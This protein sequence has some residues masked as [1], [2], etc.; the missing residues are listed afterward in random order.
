[1]AA[2]T[3][4]GV[5]LLENRCFEDSDEAR[6]EI[7]DLYRDLRVTDVCDG[8]DLVGLRDHAASYDLTKVS[9][10][11]GLDFELTREVTLTVEYEIEYDFLGC[12]T[13]E[14]GGATAEQ[15]G[16]LDEGSLVLGQLRPILSWDRR[17]NIFR[18]H[19]GTFMTQRTE[20]AHDMLPDQE[21]FYVKLDGLLSGVSAFVRPNAW[22]AGAS[23]RARDHPDRPEPG[24]LERLLRLPPQCL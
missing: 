10:I 8:M 12:P 20:L 21:V 19:R 3:P 17:D 5:R 18:P 24:L 7:L 1:M 14:C 22:P 13:V 23:C 2:H 16:R 9:L 11:P 15:L 4:E 6:K